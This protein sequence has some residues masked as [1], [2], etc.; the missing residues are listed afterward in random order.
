M[1]YPNRPLLYVGDIHGIMPHVRSVDKLA[2]AA[3]VK[4][5]IQVGD[6]G[7]HWNDNCELVTYFNERSPDNPEW[8]VCPGNHENY[9]RINAIWEAQGKVDKFLLAP[10]CYGVARGA[11]L[12]I[13]GLYHL[14]L[15]GAHSID[16]HY[17]TEGISWWPEEEPTYEEFLRFS[18]NLNTFYP[19]V[20]VTHD[21]PALVPACKDSSWAQQNVPRNLENIIRLAEWQPDRWYFG[22][23][24]YTK[25]WKIGLTDFYC[26]GM[27][28]NFQLWWDKE[29]DAREDE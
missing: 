14:F 3:G 24:H 22:H 13:E 26:C 17:R 25:H 7:I 9:A 20:V 27:G 12:E 23:H 8:I 19:P 15:G 21:A 5:I 16:R 29:N 18:D 6:F 28:G 4:T 2:V 1:L 11:L 10:G